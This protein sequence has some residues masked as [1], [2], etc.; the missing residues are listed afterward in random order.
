MKKDELFTASEAA[1]TLKISAASIKNWEKSGLIRSVKYKNR[2]FFLK[3][4]VEKLKESIE[5]GQLDRLKSRANKKYKRGSIFPNGEIRDACTKI[6]EL[7]LPLPE[8]MFLVSLKLFYDA[9]LYS[10]EN[11]SNFSSNN[12]NNEIIYKHI[13]TFK[14]T[15]SI[16]KL[17]DS[18]M[19]IKQL[20]ISSGTQ[21]FSDTAGTIY[22]SLCISGNRSI[23]G[24]FYT[25][26]GITIEMI[27][28]AVKSLKK[29][30]TRL[31]DISMIDPCC[32]TGQFIISFIKAG[33]RVENTYGMDIDPV[34][35]F[36]AKTNILLLNPEMNSEPQIFCCDA[37]TGRLPNG[38]SVNSFHLA[39][40]NP[41]WG[42]C[43]KEM[44]TILKKHY[45][46]INS[47]ERFSC[48]LIRCLELV[49]PGGVVSIVLPES[50][51]NVKK[52]RDIRKLIIDKS[53]ITKVKEHGRKFKNVFSNVITM[54]IKKE[55]SEE[56]KSTE[57]NGLIVN[58]DLTF[59]IN[60]N[61]FDTRLID[62][63]YEQPCQTLR[64][65]AEW[66][67]G[68]V[69]GD[70]KRYIKEKNSETHF[71]SDD[72]WEPVITGSDISSGKITPP[73]KYIIFKPEQFQQTAPER[74]YRANEKLVYRF[75]SKKLIFAKD[76][77]GRLTLNSANCLIPS[78]DNFSASDI[79]RLFNSEIY[80]FIYQKKYNS[81]KVLRSNLEQIP[82][83]AVEQLYKLYSDSEMNYI[84][85]YF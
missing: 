53:S 72:Y 51:T 2:L 1:H 20:K 14:I 56:N 22:Q 34:A 41:P 23:S 25:P 35:V 26:S 36:I 17:E 15:S 50:I 7:E 77:D 60:I 42:V 49:R 76:Y 43:S 69:T 18:Y 74:I 32:G 28:S 21:D 38:I 47:G 9:G 58:H 19:K 82:I 84:R 4:D 31:A 13:S 64:S 48:F 24:S 75:I 85:N 27:D 71:N 68:I 67:L 11:C 79:M 61:S 37:L 16:E 57:N 40:T 6:M 78:V 80:N 39:A 44:K 70:N 59:S 65:N 12:F 54:E 66:G 8:I 30:K 81:V 52:H 45:P 33:G 55:G 83:I 10:S 3:K 63:L 62:R 46:E 5:S 29:Q 73:M